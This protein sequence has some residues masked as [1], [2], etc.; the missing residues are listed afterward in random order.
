MNLIRPCY[1]IILLIASLASRVAA[2]DKP[3]RIKA[4]EAR[5][6]VGKQVEVVFKVKSTKNSVKRKTV[7]LDSEENFQDEKNLGIAI[8]E[9]GVSDLKQKRGVEAPAEYYKDKSIRVVGEV[10][11]ENEHAYIKVDDADH[12]DLFEE[13]AEK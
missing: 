9:V 13:K 10:V 7:F 6:H 11:I 1:L 12:L 5:Q 4:D 3:L 8:S 2:E